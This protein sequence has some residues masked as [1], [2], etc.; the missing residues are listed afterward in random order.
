LE[1][2]LGL[3]SANFAYVSVLHELMGMKPS[4]RPESLLLP[5]SACWARSTGSWYEYYRAA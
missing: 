1:R 4:G 2:L 5:D 3:G